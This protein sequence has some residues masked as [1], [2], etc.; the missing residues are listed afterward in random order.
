M[1]DY[2]WPKWHWGRFSPR[3]SVSLANSHSTDCSTFIIYVG[4]LISLWLSLFHIRVLCS[5]TKIIF[6]GWVQAVRTTKS[7]VCGAQGEYLLTEPSLSWEAANC[8][9]T[10]ELPTILWNPKVHYRVHKSPPLVPML[11]SGGI[12]KYIFFNPVACCFLYEAKDLSAPFVSFGAGTIGQ[13]V[14]DVPSRLSHPT[15]RN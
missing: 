12:C 1:W 13:I 5:T 7:W 14:A 4:V 3:T 6:L 11:S 10:Q 9:A 2:W 8:A 15:P